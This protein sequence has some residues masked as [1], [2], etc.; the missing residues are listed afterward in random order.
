[1]RRVSLRP[2]AMKLL[3]EL[4]KTYEIIIYTALDEDFTAALVKKKLDKKGV[5]VNGILS[6][7]YCFK[8][9][10][11]YIKDLRILKNRDLS[12]IVFLDTSVIS[13]CNQMDNSIIV[14]PY[15]SSKGDT[16]LFEVLAALK[17]IAKAPDVRIELRKLCS[18]LDMYKIYLKEPRTVP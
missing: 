3:N 6:R 1:M 12:K 11:Y 9:N 14:P 2:G 16:A 5:I 4:Y 15:S 13:V 18:L 10:G 17:V 8:K 7:S